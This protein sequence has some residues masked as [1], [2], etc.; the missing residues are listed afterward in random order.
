LCLLLLY[1][2]TSYLFLLKLPVN[3]EGAECVSEYPTG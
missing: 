3:E 2:D 1:S